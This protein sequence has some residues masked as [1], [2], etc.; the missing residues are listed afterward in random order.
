MKTNKK[1]LLLFTALFLSVIGV[2]GAYMLISG[3]SQETLS[4]FSTAQTEQSAGSSISPV[5]KNAY[6]D[7]PIANAV[8]YVYGAESYVRT[9]TDGTTGPIPVPFERDPRFD[10]T[11]KKNWA[12]TTVAVYADGY[13]PYILFGCAVY[14][15]EERSGPEI[16]LV[17]RSYTSSDS[18][19]VTMEAPARSWV[20]ELFS[21]LQQKLT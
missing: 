21:A 8:V 19:I 11:V 17:P 16:L 1:S 6:T 7:T 12:E 9:D 13:V 18:P 4:A 5:V 15:N 3:N 14:E 10:D 2:T 20:E